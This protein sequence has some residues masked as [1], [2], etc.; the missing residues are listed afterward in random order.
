MFLSSANRS[1]TSDPD[2][3]EFEYFCL[4]LQSG[5]NSQCFPLLGIFPIE[6]DPQKKTSKDAHGS[7]S[8]CV[9]VCIGN[10]PRTLHIPGL[11]SLALIL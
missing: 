8:L 5:Y 6:R 4:E 11:F 2:Y 10:E 1:L 9:S 3:S 7:L